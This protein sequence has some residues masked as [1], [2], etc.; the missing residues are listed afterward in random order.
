M[1]MN[2]QI[3]Q[4]GVDDAEAFSKLRRE[5]TADNPIPMGLTMEEVLARP[6]QGF[7]EQLSY[8]EPNAAFGAFVDGELV[9]SAVVCGSSITG[10]LVVTNSGS[11]L[12][13][14]KTKLTT[15][16][17]HSAKCSNNF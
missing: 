10:G 13:M 9:A 8:P 17:R 4:L 12:S 7:R 6:L 2:F 1:A 3:R 11:L 15:W 14:T 5:R 16:L